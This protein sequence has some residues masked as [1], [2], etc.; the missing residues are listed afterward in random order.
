V[1]VLKSVIYHTHKAG[2]EGN[3]A[4]DYEHHFGREHSRGIVPILACD[5]SGR[6]WVCGGSYRCP[7]PGITG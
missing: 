3:R 4:F 6:L 7:L 2:E 5:V 1:G